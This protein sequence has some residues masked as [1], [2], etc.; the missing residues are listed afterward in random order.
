MN[1]KSQLFKNVISGF[2]GQ[3]IA[4][5]LGLIVPRFFIMSYGSDV[6]GLLSTITQIFTYMALLEAGIGQAAKNLL[7]KPFQE[8]DKDKISETYSV[9]K[10][11]FGRFTFIY[12]IGVIAIA[13][14][15]PFT[16]F[17]NNFI[18]YFKEFNY[19]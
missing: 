3:L 16:L 9:A 18:Q 15:L 1:K 7:Y 19:N 11:Y 17:S 13:F 6:N 12:G 2:G 4:I 10:T 14:I 8:K 5:I